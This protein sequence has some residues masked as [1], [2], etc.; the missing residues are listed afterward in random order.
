M[1]DSTRTAPAARWRTGLIALSLGTVLTVAV[2]VRADEPAPPSDGAPADATPPSERE[3]LADEVL[4]IAT[5]RPARTFDV[6]ASTTVV[7][8]GTAVR[9]RLRRT[10]PDLLLDVPGVMVQRTAYGQA[11]PFI[12]GFTGY[13]TV[14]LM[15]GIR[16]NNSVFRSGPNQYWSTLDPFTI[17]RVEVVRGPASEAPRA[18]GIL[19]QI[20][21]IVLLV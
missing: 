19:R 12:R 9:Q 10:F 17:D 5:R 11:S 15:D 8:G 2:P 13:H 20:R 4:V 21:S 18:A 14:L 7:D 16:I 1:L 6:P 3:L